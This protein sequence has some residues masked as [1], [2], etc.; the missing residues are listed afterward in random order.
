MDIKFYEISQTSSEKVIPPLLYKIYEQLTD[1]ILLL[2]SNK[3]EI[4]K[5]HTEIVEG[6]N[7]NQKARA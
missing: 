3:E 1:N 4:A 7:L 2:L 6:C 5:F